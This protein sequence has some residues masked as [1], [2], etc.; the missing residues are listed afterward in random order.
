MRFPKEKEEIVGLSIF[1]DPKIAVDSLLG[2][3]AIRTDVNQLAALIICFWSIFSSCSLFQPD[4]FTNPAIFS[5]IFAAQNDFVVAT[6]LSYPPL[7]PDKADPGSTNL[8]PVHL[9]FAP[10]RRKRRQN[11]HQFEKWQANEH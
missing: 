11:C 5:K 1:P 3:A 6:H 4:R 9:P 8:N 7:F 2:E 10:I